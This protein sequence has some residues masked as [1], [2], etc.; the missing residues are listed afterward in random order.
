MRT[1]TLETSQ[2]LPRISALEV[3][4]GIFDCAKINFFDS[5]SALAFWWGILHTTNAAYKSE[6]ELVFE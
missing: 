6:C 2:K 1:R 5:L 4:H 3:S